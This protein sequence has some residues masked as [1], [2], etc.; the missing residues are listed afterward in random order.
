MTSKEKLIL[1]IKSEYIP[2]EVCDILLQLAQPHL[3]KGILMDIVYGKDKGGKVD[4]AYPSDYAQQVRNLLPKFRG[5]F[6]VY[7]YNE[8]TDYDP[9]ASRHG[10]F[11]NV[12]ERTILKINYLMN[13][14]E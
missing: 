6:M 4:S 10:T 12:A 5:E 1:A 7:D 8:P 11:E 14:R 3:G 2:E 9:K 13:N